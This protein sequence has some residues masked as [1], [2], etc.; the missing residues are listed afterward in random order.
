MVS[1]VYEPTISWGSSFQSC[2]S[3]A[4][5]LS[6]SP[7]KG[8]CPAHQNS[9]AWPACPPGQRRLRP[10]QTRL[11]SLAVACGKCRPLCKLM[12]NFLLRIF[13]KRLRRQMAHKRVF[14]PLLTPTGCPTIQVN[15]DIYLELVSD[16]TSQRVQFHKTA[17][18]FRYRSQV[19]GTHTLTDPLFRLGN[20][21]ERPTQLRKDLT[22]ISNNDEQPGEVHRVLVGKGPEQGLLSSWSWGAQPPG[23]WVG[24]C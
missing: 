7:L 11:H 14:F 12:A 2:P 23:S 22:V 24:G 15:P 13:T 19:P 5:C 18:N 10:P 6:E 4:P 8:N 1:T 9:A 20:L 17:P 21:P 3:S 16:P